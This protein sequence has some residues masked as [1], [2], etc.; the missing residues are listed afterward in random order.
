MSD[1]AVQYVD[2][3]HPELCTKSSP[4]SGSISIRKSIFWPALLQNIVVV[5]SRI[6]PEQYKFI[7]RS[8]LRCGFNGEST[9]VLYRSSVGI[10]RPKELP[11]NYFIE[12]NLNPD[13]IA[14]L[15]KNFVDRICEKSVRVKIAV[16]YPNDDSL[17]P[18]NFNR[19]EDCLKSKP[20]RCTIDFAF[21]GRWNQLFLLILEILRAFFPEQYDLL[22]NE[23]FTEDSRPLLYKRKPAWMLSAKQLSDG[24]W[25][26]SHGSTS[27]LVTRIKNFSDFISDGAAR[28]KIRYVSR[29][30]GASAVKPTPR[31]VVQ[32]KPVQPKAESQPEVVK[33]T[34]SGNG[35]QKVDF[36]HPELCKGTRPV[37]CIIKNRSI[38]VGNTWRD[39][40]VNILDVLREINP[41][42]YNELKFHGFRPGTKPR[43]LH[44]SSLLRNSK[45]LRDG[46]YVEMH[47]ISQIVEL[48]KQFVDYIGE[49]SLPIEILYVSKENSPFQMSFYDS[50]DVKDQ[51]L[52][53]N[54]SDE[55][56][57]TDKS[58]DK[59]VDSSEKQE[60]YEQKQLDDEDSEDNFNNDVDND[61]SDSGELEGNFNEGNSDGDFNDKDDDSVFESFNDNYEE[62]NNDLYN[63]LCNVI[64]N[65]PNWNKGIEF[66]PNVIRILSDRCSTELDEY[67]IN[68]FRNRFCFKRGNRFSNVY[69]LLESVAP[70]EVQQ[71]IVNQAH[72]WLEEYGLFQLECLY[73][74]FKDQLDQVGVIHDSDNFENYLVAIYPKY[75]FK[76]IPSIICFG[77][78]PYNYPRFVRDT[79]RY[80]DGSFK[81]LG[82]HIT[83]IVKDM[84]EQMILKE[85]LCAQIPC[86]N[87]SMIDK[88]INSYTNL[89]SCEY[90]DC[91]YYQTIQAQF[92]S[93]GL[94][95]NFPVMISETLNTIADQGLSPNVETINVILTLYHISNGKSF[96]QQFGIPKD[97]S[98]FRDL[99]AYFYNGTPKREWQNGEFVVVSSQEEKNTP[100]NEQDNLFEDEQFESYKSDFQDETNNLPDDGKDASRYGETNYE[101]FE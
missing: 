101:G 27:A 84:D 37:E 19:P 80:W 43:L 72:A 1:S 61:D 100:Q 63:Q 45:K 99:I 98:V 40:L 26:E 7:T 47:E 77:W 56:D 76:K 82:E 55:F 73:N 17:Y 68:D 95:E 60:S 52:E 32:P 85:D 44:R 74:R 89:T 22:K 12:V 5:L 62:M 3:D 25:V 65:E 75:Q 8:L 78:R 93:Y 81:E 36:R 14:T 87:S 50:R 67:V 28:L 42:R 29:N 79:N 10:I 15:I 53:D 59:D 21:N 71:E 83:Q 34:Q 66:N 96:R 38:N 2:F 92:E 4:V 51:K 49:G 64:Q 88:F 94:P 41:S 11:N 30:T 6:D 20:A 46:Y 69:V 39:L 18:I 9:P 57:K 90:N 97:D 35:P 58:S 31:P 13:K 86:I 33:P 16:Q 70:L 23:G 54:V 91:T 48:I 24:Y